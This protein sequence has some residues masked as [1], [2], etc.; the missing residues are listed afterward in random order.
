MSFL[1]DFTR[2][3][4][5]CLLSFIIIFLPVVK[6]TTV[7]GVSS[8]TSIKS[9]FTSTFVPLILVTSITAAFPPK[10][11]KEPAPRFPQISILCFTSVGCLPCCQDFTV[12]P[13]RFRLVSSSSNVSDTVMIRLFAWKPRWVVIISVNSE[14]RSTLLISRTPVFI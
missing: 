7:S 2:F 6:N 5:S 10:Y 11:L 4:I 13:Y 12:C 9:G 3:F 8:T 14:E 1:S